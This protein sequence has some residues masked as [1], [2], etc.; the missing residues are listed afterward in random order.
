MQFSRFF[1]HHEFV[2]FTDDLKLNM[3]IIDDCIKLQKDLNQFKIWCLNYGLNINI[4]KC[5]QITRKKIKKFAIN[6]TLII[7]INC[8]HPYRH[9]LRYILFIYLFFETQH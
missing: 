1:F 5:Y 6:I 8:K 2:L 4:Y 7:I 3:P 9:R